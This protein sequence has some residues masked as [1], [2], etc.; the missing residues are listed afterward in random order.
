[1]RALADWHFLLSVSR[2]R[3]PAAEVP[4]TNLLRAALAWAEERGLG[5][6]GTARLPRDGEPPGEL[7]YDFGLAAS[8]EGQAIPESQA[9]EF[10]NWLRGWAEARGLELR[11]GFEEYPPAGP[12]AA[13]PPAAPDPARR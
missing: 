2:V 8:R 1:M 11:G 4:G 13:G 12:D 5:V 10:L 7:V 6:S 9:G 3:P